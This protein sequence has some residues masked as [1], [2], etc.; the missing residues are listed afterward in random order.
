MLVKTYSFICMLCR[1]S[2]KKRLS[3]P[4]IVVEEH[5]RLS[6]MNEEEESEDPGITIKID[7][8]TPTIQTP[9]GNAN[10]V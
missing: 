10:F 9:V 7:C 1:S 5:K 6:I 8:P 3:K 4:E 2:K